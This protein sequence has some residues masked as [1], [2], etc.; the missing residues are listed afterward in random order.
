MCQSHL[1]RNWLITCQSDEWMD[2][3]VEHRVGLGVREKLTQMT[4][5]SGV[6]LQNHPE[7]VGASS[8]RLT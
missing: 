8:Y 2:K 7:A 4:E 6:A 5:D 3:A 1:C